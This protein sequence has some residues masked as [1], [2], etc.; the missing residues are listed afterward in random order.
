MTSALMGISP[1]FL[2]WCGVVVSLLCLRLIV[3]LLLSFRLERPRTCF[4]WFTPVLVRLLLDFLNSFS[5]LSILPFVHAFPSGSS[6][7]RSPCNWASGGSFPFYSTVCYLLSMFNDRYPGGVFFCR[8]HIPF[9]PSCF[10]FKKPSPFPL[11]VTL[12]M[13]LTTCVRCQL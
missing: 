4:S 13:L 9:F 2:F 6:R 1:L 11:R 8:N 7:K 3:F 5:S 12:L 10:P